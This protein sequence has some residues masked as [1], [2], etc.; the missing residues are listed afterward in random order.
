MIGYPLKNTLS[1]YGT[2]NRG[3]CR[4]EGS[5]L[6]TVEEHSTISSGADGVVRGDNLAGDPVEIAPEAIVSM[7]FWGFTPALFPRLEALFIEFLEAH[8]QEMKSECY[9]PSVIDTLIQTEQTQC[10]V[11][12]TDGAWFGVTYPDDK[13]FVQASIAALI[14]SGEYPVQV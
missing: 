14:A 1:E 11:I 3:I 10:V 7:N 8:G 9:I 13:P 6:Q 2:V 12:E 4:V 5:A